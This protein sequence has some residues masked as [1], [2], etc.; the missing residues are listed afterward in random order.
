[1]TNTRA[2][3]AFI[4]TFILV[5]ISVLVYFCIYWTSYQVYFRISNW[6]TNTAYRRLKRGK[7]RNL[8]VS[9][10]LFILFMVPW[11]TM[12][13]AHFILWVIRGAVKKL[14]GKD[15]K[16]TIFPEELASPTTINNK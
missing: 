3:L 4:P 15:W 10:P 11:C 6:E 16:G 9:V 1:M 12:G 8:L 13:I 14:T 5:F 7:Q 2:A